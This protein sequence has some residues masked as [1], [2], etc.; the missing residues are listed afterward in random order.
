[1]SEQLI[2]GDCCAPLV[3]A[4]TGRRAAVEAPELP[5]GDLSAYVRDTGTG[6]KS[7]HFLVDGIT[8]GA[9][10]QTIERDLKG[11][12]GIALA[13]VNLSTSRLSVEFDPARTDPRAMVG[14]LAGIGYRAVPF[15]PAA[16]LADRAEEEKELL[17]AMAVAG[18]AA[19][20]VMLLSVSIWSGHFT[21]MG[22][23]TRDLMHWLSAIVAVPAIVYAGRPFFRSALSALS[24]FRTNMDVPISLGVLLA[25]LMS[26]SETM[27]GAEHAYF[28][29]AISLLFF[30]LIGRYLDLRAR[31]RARA[32]AENLLKLNAS[33][34]TLLAADGS[35]RIVPPD[36]VSVD[37][38]VLVA[39]GE[40][41]PVDGRV[42]S[43]R[44]DIDMSLITGETTPEAVAPGAKLFAGALNLSGPLTLRVEAVGEGTLLAEIARLME[45]AEQRRARYVAIADRVSRAYAPVVHLLALATFLGWTILG[46]MAWQE[47]LMI[48]V[49][50]LIITCPC[51]LGLAVPVVQVV[52]SGRLLRRG[53]LIKSGTALERLAEIDTVVFDKTGTLTEGRPELLNISA[54]DP[55]CLRLGA[56]MAQASRHPLARAL[57]RAAGPVPVAD[58]VRELPG[59]GLEWDGP[60]GLVRMGSRGFVGV[61]EDEGA[62]DPELWLARSGREPVRFAFHDPLRADAAAVVAA[63]RSAGLA[64][65]MLSGDRPAAVA[66][67]AE[68]VGLGE[69]WL[70]GQAPDAKVARLEELAAR[71]AKVLMVGDG[72]NDAPALA[73]AFVSM[74]PT[75]AA[76]ISQNAADLVFQGRVLA[77]VLEAW[78]VARRSERLVRQNFAL[79][80]LYNVLTV[81]VAVAGFVTPLIAAV[82]MSSSSLIVIGNALRLSLGAGQRPTT[83][84]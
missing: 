69:A 3:E 21:D 35:T 7:V 65:E 46:G 64:V 14:R 53:V 58:G 42:V 55:A 45:A 78:R 18:F 1:M 8:C 67:A 84:D 59:R 29:S 56:S 36:A 74:S 72:L 48:S 77:P 6:L 66:R 61:P 37:A 54:H 81:P 4:D 44:S 34:V 11:D 32:A 13:R 15:D 75:T 68:G 23:A 38:L 40:R 80:F 73:A 47:A 17:K 71:G 5:N 49:A 26:L 60:D 57:A 16:F 31:G 76:D 63:F 30:L 25:T 52:A 62:R 20:N 83:R 19:A 22:D 33:A 70:A 43:G 10:I 12:R 24:A 51:A 27:R 41:A 9:C 79:S 50:V 39:P 28:D 2:G 82:A